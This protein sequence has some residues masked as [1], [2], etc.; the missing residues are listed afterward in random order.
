MSLSGAELAAVAE[1]LRSIEGA[2][3]QKLGMPAPSTVVLECRQP[4]RTLFV[5]LVAESGTARASLIPARP[6]S[7]A[8]PFGL[9]GALRTHLTDA[10]IAH[11]R[12][13]GRMLELR[14][15]TLKCERSLLLE[16]GSRGALLLL[17]GNE[18]KL[19]AAAPSA[20]LKT[21]G[22]RLGG[23]YEAPPEG[24]AGTVRWQETPSI[25]EAI[26]ALYQA[27][28]PK[29]AAPSA[30]LLAPLRSAC[31]R[32]QRTVD[33]VSA[34]AARIDEAEV[35]K[36]YGD[37]L[38]PH[39]G[40]I[41]RGATEALVT[42][43]TEKGEAQVA[44]PLLPNLSAHENV[45]R[46]Y[47]LHQRLTRAR[48][49]VE[50]RQAEIAYRLER[51]RALL[52][53]AEA[54]GDDALREAVVAEARVE[55]LLSKTPERAGAGATAQERR[56]PQ[57][58][59][60]STTGRRIWVGRNARGNDELT[61]HVAGANDLWLHARGWTGSH[62]VVPGPAPD[63][64]TLLDA[65]TLAAH[66]SAARGERLVEVAATLRRHVR[67]PKGGAPGAV[68]YSQERT[69]A[70]RLED[71]RLRRLLAAES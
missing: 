29:P 32:L 28:T 55:G 24:D 63:A 40:R 12:S 8:T 16:I 33:N 39:L 26:E 46:Y 19:L 70:L 69:I 54:A 67:K 36:R 15:E 68:Q 38:K 21:R 53:R 18:R 5:Q 17:L 64:E 52:A 71:E 48:A 4:G 60:T 56:P 3:I 49:M 62:V 57:R 50:A 20:V 34:D 59:F 45:A 31:K 14:C 51:A 42:Q 25:S 30:S 65:A 11:V 22:L 37:L 66:F 10:R 61:L 13:H 43:W 9:Q 41:A 58:T 2:R 1:E 44:V 23:P 47:H 35:Y 6:A 7:P 27:A